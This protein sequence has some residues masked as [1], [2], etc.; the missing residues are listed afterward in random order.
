MVS[1]AGR[2][3]GRGGLPVFLLVLAWSSVVDASSCCRLSFPLLSS[4]CSLS[5][6]PFSFAPLLRLLSVCSFVAMVKWCGGDGR[7]CLA[8][9]V[10]AGSGSLCLGFALG[11]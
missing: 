4:G 10:V 7:L 8:S 2:G 6:F 11:W 3:G 1:D 9:V 5:V